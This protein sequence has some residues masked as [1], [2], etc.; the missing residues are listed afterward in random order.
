M[1]KFVILV[2]RDHGAHAN[3]TWNQE[4]ALG[5]P[6]CQFNTWYVQFLVNT[7][8]KEVIQIKPESTGQQSVRLMVEGDC[9]TIA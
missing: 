9:I 2:G 6:T 3:F 5:L 7:R 8:N 4:S 1:T